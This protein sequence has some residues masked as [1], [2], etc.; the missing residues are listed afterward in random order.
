MGGMKTRWRA[1]ILLGFLLPPSAWALEELPEPTPVPPWRGPLP[2]YVQPSLAAYDAVVHDVSESL[3]RIGFEPQ[4]CIDTSQIPEDASTVILIGYPDLISNI[5]QLGGPSLTHPESFLVR[6]VVGTRYIVVTAG[7]E[8]GFLYGAQELAERMALHNEFPDVFPR[9]GR[10]Y[11]EVR[12]YA[13]DWPGA[14][15]KGQVFDDD[16]FIGP[17]LRHLLRNRFNM[18]VL[19]YRGRAEDLLDRTGTTG[20]LAARRLQRVAE[21]ARARLLPVALWLNPDADLDTPLAENDSPLARREQWASALFEL[22][23]AFPTIS[24]GLWPDDETRDR[25]MGDANQWFDG[26]IQPMLAAGRNP[27]SLLFSGLGFDPLLFRGEIPPYLPAP[28]L[29]GLKWCGD[30][31]VACLEPKY[32]EG[33]WFNPRPTDF[34]LLWVLTDEDVQCFRSAYFQRTQELLENMGSGTNSPMPAGFVFFPKGE[35]YGVESLN[36]ESM[37]F[38]IP[39]K[40][41]YRKHWYRHALW[42]RLGYDPRLGME[43]FGPFFVDGYGPEVGQALIQEEALG[44]EILWRVSRFHWCYRGEDWYPEACLAPG[45]GGPYGLLGNRTGPVYRDRGELEHP[46]E[47]VL[48]FAFSLTA[49]PR[50]LSILEAA[51]YE[52]AG[53]PQP[54]YEGH[55]LTPLE[56]AEIL[57]RQTVELDSIVSRLDKLSQDSP[58]HFE[59]RHMAAD[60]VLQ[61]L[62]GAYYRSKIAATY[63]FVMALAEGSKEYREQAAQEMERGVQAWKSFAERAD[64]IYRF[65]VVGSEKLKAWS[66]LNAVAERD[67]QIIRDHPPFERVEFEQ[68]VYGPFVESSTE[69]EAF[70]LSLAVS[71]PPPGAATGSVR[72]VQFTSPVPLEQGW[73]DVLNHYA[74]Y[75]AFDRMPGFAEGNVAWTPVPIPEGIQSF[76][77]LRLV[78]GDIDAVAWGG[79]MVLDRRLEPDVDLSGGVRLVGPGPERTLWVRSSRPPEGNTGSSPA[80]GFALSLEPDFPFTLEPAWWESDGLVVRV[81][82][83]LDSGR[84]GSIRFEVE[85]VGEGWEIPPSAPAPISLGTERT[86]VLPCR[87]ADDWAALRLSAL[88]RDERVRIDFFPPQPRSNVTLVTGA[89][90][91]FPR[92]A[93][94]PA[95]WGVSTSLRGWQT[96]LLYRVNEA[97]LSGSRGGR[98]ARQLIVEWLPGVNPANLEVEYQSGAGGKPTWRSV[99]ADG[100]DWVSSTIELPGLLEHSGAVEPILLRLSRRDH[101]DLWVRQVRFE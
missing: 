70:E 97:Y 99:T 62:L 47:S 20:M 12:G 92:L 36:R 8:R 63:W 19:H 75:V 4:I 56:V 26:F 58:R 49:D 81:E 28:P 79:R 89:V 24:F 10:P 65:P 54:H 86:F 21:E 11:L 18:L 76:L 52:L 66:D 35:E 17:F 53:I 90:G 16:Q 42:G 71:G 5:V 23:Q 96:A 55:K 73:L 2:M 13:I 84:L 101:E 50:E 94:T 7:G 39:W 83:E 93:E 88:W 44:E 15:P 85:P 1:L 48:E 100:E 68:P 78:G 61:R 64:R 31:P 27:S 22:S 45:E 40:W 98:G 3:L 46:F 74:G 60:M 43:D 33:G 57:R 41:G 82:N 80:W 14:G 87:M 77:R 25:S 37:D 9:Q 95:G 59:A 51:G 6:R 38:R 69:L 91:T 67:V 32:I 29:V 30:H 34:R 72:L